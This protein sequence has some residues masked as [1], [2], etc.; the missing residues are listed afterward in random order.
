MIETAKDWNVPPW[1]VTGEE[2]TR[3]R[4][5][6]WRYRHELYAGELAAR[7][8]REVDELKLKEYGRLNG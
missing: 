5:L 8:R 2:L 4:R 7:R 1:V 6:V 3:W